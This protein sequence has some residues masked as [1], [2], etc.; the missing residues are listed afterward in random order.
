M[1]TPPAHTAPADADALLRLIDEVLRELQPGTVRHAS[2]DSTLDRELGLDSL[3]RVELLARIERRFGLRLPTEVLVAAET[4]RELLRAMAQAARAGGDAAA[5][6]ASPPPPP[7]SAPESVIEGAAAALPDS[8]AT[9]VEVLAWHL[10][11]HPERT[12]VR[13]LVDDEHAETLSYA[14]LHAAGVRLA[15]ALVALGV[16]PG[17][18]VALMLPSGLD[19]FRCFFAI[20]FAGAVPVPMYPPA[21]PN[22]IEEHLRRQAGILRNCEARVLITFDRV[23]PL[24]RMLAGLVPTLAHVSTPAALAAAGSAPQPPL[25]LRSSAL[26][27]IQYTSGSTGDPKGVALSHANLLANIRAWGAAAA[28][29]PQDVCVSWLPLYHD[30]GLI[31]TWLGSLYHG[32]TLVLMSPL[33][34]LAR[35]ERWLWAIHR[36]RGT[37]TA[38]PN[39]A[40]ELCVKRLADTALDGLD[41]S[42]WRLAANGAEPVNPDTLA[43]FATAFARY[44]LDARILTPVYGLAE[45]AVGLCVP[46]PGRG[47]VVDR[48]R[49]ASVRLG[50]QVEP[51]TAAAATAGPVNASDATPP[52]SAGHAAGTAKAVDTANAAG[53]ASA[54]SA[55]DTLRVVSCGPALPGHALRV[56]DADGRPLP[57]R[58]V[59]AVEFRGPSA[60]AG[61]YRNPTATAALI[62]DG[63]LATGDHGYLADGELYLTGRAKE[64]IIRAGRN[65]YPYDLEQAVG[66]L[67]GVR[68]G[69]VAV[70]G[71]DTPGE[72]DERLVVVAETRVQ[73]AG[74]RAALEAR[75]TAAA[76][77]A[78]GLA[79]DAVV[80]APPHA[81]LKTSSGKIRRAAIRDAWLAGTLGAPSRAAWLQVLR[82]Q[83][84]SLAGRA[85]RAALAVPGRLQA[86]WAWSAFLLLA[87]LAT[88]AILTLPRLAQRWA[89]CHRLARLHAR[90]CGCALRVEGADHLPATGCVLVAN[91]ASY[92][93]GLVL[94]AALPQPVRFVAKAE[95]RDSRLLGPLFERMDTCFVRRFDP[96]HGVE[97]ADTLAAGAGTGAPLLFF[98]EG[99]FSA[100]PGLQAF[101]LGAFQSAARQGL[102]VVPVALAGTRAVL[103]DGSWQPRPGALTV[104][105]CAPHA[106]AGEDWHDLLALRDAV[107]ADILT[108]C[109]E[110]DATRR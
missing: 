35:P 77:D 75:I 61:Y 6:A 16:R 70:F 107:R 30:M 96:G 2:L 29:V 73:D 9:L 8:A 93:D 84:A 57:E 76:M 90:L 7:S 80:L 66:E 24:A 101:R 108:H 13:F 1:P 44:G 102:P 86:A 79:P 39:F 87:P 62:R 19:F 3:S 43:R 45:C 63:W 88:L 110:D 14:Q 68:K 69:C 56:V 15:G 85:R 23:R 38:A 81:V 31:G 104:T 60:T 11:R 97:D 106:P 5:A 10:A 72:A 20:L 51:A 28:V 48:V 91:H 50:G 82:L 4:P 47:V 33:D 92:I 46:P 74:A 94:A 54:A 53:T 83:L 71:C 78:L 32:C 26:G 17:D 42:C 41:L 65:L 49:R 99:T 22:Q 58:T 67:P 52:A 103:P 55:A 36:Y 34:F 12:H 18:C 40:F 95:L 21:R 37:V 27:L 105:I 59:G 109:G 89:V 64:M 25:P 100:R 98:A